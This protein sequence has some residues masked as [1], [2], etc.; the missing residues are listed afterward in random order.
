MTIRPLS[1]CCVAEFIGTFLLVFLGCGAV[2]VAVLTGDLTGLWQVGVVWG[3]AIMGAIYS[4][5][6]ISGAH[7]NPAITFG[8]AAWRLFPAS[9]ILP[10]VASQLAGAFVAAAALYALFQPQLAAKEAAK[11]VV[12][13]ELGSEITAMCYCEFFPNPGALA[14]GE[15]PLNVDELVARQAL[16]S[17]F[18][19]C[20]AEFLGTLIL[21]MVVAAVT[22]DASL[23]GPQ[24]M[25][26]L[27][28]GF[29]VAALICVIAPLTQACFNPARDF[30]PRV[31]AALAGWGEVALPG[32]RSQTGFL[33]VYIL[34]PIAGGVTGI[35][36]YQK[37]LRP[38]SSHAPAAAK[39]GEKS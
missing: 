21:G 24:R 7:I 14:G 11:S 4:V 23:L 35:G 2:H 9:R 6:A 33:T 13:G 8:M 15:G 26:P 34:A 28:I 32:L 25:A 39:S 22:N 17:E 20:L 16:V 30:G 19:A 1:A 18:T 10:Y 36:L 12:R 37:L 38:H 5:G 27:F 3:I 29:T 31:F